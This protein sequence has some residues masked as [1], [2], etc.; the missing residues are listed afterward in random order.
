[1][2]RLRPLT[3]VNTNSWKKNKQ[4]QNV[5]R[6]TTATVAVDAKTKYVIVIFIIFKQEVIK[7]EAKS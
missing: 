2:A 7:E 4:T 6:K 5:K 1:L 3:K